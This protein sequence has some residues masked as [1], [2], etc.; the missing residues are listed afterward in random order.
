MQLCSRPK[1]HSSTAQESWG[2]E[3]TAEN[4]R[5]QIFLTQLRSRYLGK[6]TRNVGAVVN[7]VGSDWFITNSLNETRLQKNS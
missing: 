7:V 6:C 1:S 3:E 4:F 5:Q 2:E